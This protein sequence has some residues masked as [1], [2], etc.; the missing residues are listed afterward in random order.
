VRGLILAV[1][2][3]GGWI[4]WTVRAARIQREAVA[5]LQRSGSSVSYNWQ[6]RNVGDFPDFHAIP[7]APNWLVACLG[8]DYFGHV[9][10]VDFFG[11]DDDMAH[12]RTLDRLETLW[13]E[14]RSPCTDAGLRH[15]SGMTQLHS[16]S[17]PRSHVTDAGL[18]W[19][20]GLTGLKELYLNHTAIGDAGLAHLRR[21]TG[22]RCLELSGTRI[23]DD[24]LVHLEGLDNLGA[25]TL[26]DTRITDTGLAH[27]AGLRSLHLVNLMDT[28]VTDTGVRELHRHRPSVKIIFERSDSPRSGASLPSPPV[29][30][31]LASKR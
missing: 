5:A 10:D 23:A 7:P 29:S 1:L 13:I 26:Q 25:L 17:L 15:L 12:L 27:L 14:S 18:T 31:G 6:R 11:D 20:S 9:T 24:G 30:R 4:G 19:V 8:V 22:L 16:L 21:L 28:Q 3:V 2:V